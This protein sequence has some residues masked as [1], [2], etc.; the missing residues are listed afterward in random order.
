[1]SEGFDRRRFLG[2]LSALLVGFSLQH[3]LGALAVELVTG[4]EANRIDGVDKTLLD[5]G[6]VDAWLVLLEDGRVVIYSGKVELGTGVETALRQIVAEELCVAFAST[7]II[8][9]DTW[10][11]PDQG[12]TAG[13][14]TIQR[15]GAQL[16]R[17]AASARQELLSRAGEHLRL[18]AA[19]LHCHDGRVRAADGRSLA[20]TELLDGEGFARRVD[21]DAALLPVARYRLVGTSV[22]RVDIPPKVFGDYRFVQDIRLPG[23]LHGRVLRPPCTGVSTPRARLRSIDDSA[24]PA[25]AQLLR[26]G[27]FVGVV[28]EDEWLAIQAARAVRLDWEVSRDLPPMSALHEHLLAGATR[29]HRVQDKGDVETRFAQLEQVHEAEYRWPFQN[30]DSIGPSCAVA[31]VG[32][33][34]A[35]VWSGTQGVYPLR[36]A[37]AELLGLDEHAVR[38]IFVE[39]SGCYGHNGADDVAGDAA[40]LS[41]LSGR[42]VRVQWSRADE[43]G[44]NPKGPA[45]VMRLRGGLDR[46]G[47]IAA[48]QFDNWSSTHSTRPGRAGGAA[49]L[50]AGQ[51]ARGL[52]LPDGASGNGRNAPVDY[53]FAHCRVISHVLPVSRSP[54][55]P[56]ALR[57]LGAVQNTF[58][59]ESFMD[60]LAHRVGIDPLEF[61]LRYLR[62]SRAQ[63][64]LERA[65]RLAGWEPA[66][67]APPPRWDG[68]PVRGRG[69]SYVRYENENAYVGMVVEVEASLEGI[70]VLKVWVAHDCGLIVNPD[71]VR[72]QIEG[73]VLQTL[74]R[75]LKEEVRFH[76]SGVSSLEW[77]SY[78]LLTFME[79]PEV[80]I[81]LIDRRNKPSVGAGEATSAAVPAAVANAL[82]AATGVR[83]RQVPLTRERL[84]AGWEAG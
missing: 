77:G 4:D 66:P 74:S 22:P 19:A 8:Q 32:D 64:V 61:R 84:R 46:H 12:L 62:D 25:G 48:W 80:R 24:L 20:F 81:A 67:L 70:R 78:P 10:L 17:A 31:D 26:E 3:P 37:L 14:K 7:S 53:G 2:G 23:M 45:M 47:E 51:L 36:A 39:A 30:H 38:V 41:R 54:L 33:D 65:A 58:A 73:N 21:P 55:R 68:S 60:E 57:G 69:L 13:S 6:E 63:A 9:G 35:T 40:L 29:E 52:E 28:A 34:E 82:F 49:T 11:T 1:M 43:H 44:W 59:N 50:L 71:G 75:T 42:P 18:P 16:R 79:I 72:N 56:S 15:G 76:A 5:V 83:L 27:N